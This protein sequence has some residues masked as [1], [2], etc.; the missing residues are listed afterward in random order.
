MPPHA[1]AAGFYARAA[2]DAGAEGRAAAATAV[3]AAA[4][5]FVVAHVPDGDDGLLALL[6]GPADELLLSLASA[7]QNACYA[8][9]VLCH[10][11]PLFLVLRGAIL[12]WLESRRGGRGLVATFATASSTAPHPG[13]VGDN[14]G[15]ADAHRQPLVCSAADHSVVSSSRGFSVKL[16]G[17][18]IP[19]H[20]FYLDPAVALRRIPPR[21]CAVPS[22]RGTPSVPGGVQPAVSLHDI[23]FTHR[24]RDTS[25]EHLT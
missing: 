3:A 22:V 7:A 23:R 19:D 4:D 14:S 15:G 12:C 2:A 13:A 9:Y 6:L 18:Y 25:F 21:R 5:A 10:M 11:A 17:A 8:F 16:C 24:R 1:H 20:L